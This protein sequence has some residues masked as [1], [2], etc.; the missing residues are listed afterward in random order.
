[1]CTECDASPPDAEPSRRAPLDP[2]VEAPVH[3]PASPSARPGG[4]IAADAIPRT[5]FPVPRLPGPR[6][7]TLGHCRRQI[8]AGQ[9][10]VPA[11]VGGGGRSR[12][13][14]EYRALPAAG[15]AQLQ[16]IGQLATIAR[17][18]RVSRV[19]R[20]ALGATVRVAAADAKRTSEAN[21]RSTR[22]TRM[23]E[24]PREARSFPASSAEK[25]A[26]RSRRMSRHA[27][28]ATL[29]FA[30][31]LSLPVLGPPVQ[32]QDTR[33][34]RE[35]AELRARAEAGDA[36]AVQPRGQVRHRFGCAGGQS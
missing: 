34:T 16:R 2:H 29:A 15:P 5:A 17:C 13:G 6:H 36:S 19:S 1:M 33:I 22:P 35:L 8:R 7:L 31:V 12:A 3:R 24:S 23:T 10:A 14:R 26:Q 25:D 28:G 9:R 4:P 20:R 27:L 18:L 32:A 11:R 21:T 30:A